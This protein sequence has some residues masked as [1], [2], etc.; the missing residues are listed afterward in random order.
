MEN[1]IQSNQAV[2]VDSGGFNI[3]V[4]LVPALRG[5]GYESQKPVVLEHFT[6]ITEEI[7]KRT[8]SLHAIDRNLD[9][10]CGVAAFVLGKALVDSEGPLLERRRE[11][12]WRRLN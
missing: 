2:R 9:P 1:V 10:F 6:K 4:T 5:A 8:K 7:L 12:K 3:R 11:P